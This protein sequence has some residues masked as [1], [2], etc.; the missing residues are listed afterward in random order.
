VMVEWEQV[1]VGS[2][3]VSE[4]WLIDRGVGT[5]GGGFGE[6]ERVLAD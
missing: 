5:C 3:R 4:C 2:G 1:V 6:G